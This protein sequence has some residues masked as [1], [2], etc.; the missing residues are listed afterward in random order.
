[1]TY[2][3]Q[4]LIQYSDRICLSPLCHVGKHIQSFSNSKPRSF[5]D[6]IEKDDATTLASSLM[7]K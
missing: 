1:M 3:R 6:V 2:W 4:K 7:M 5:G